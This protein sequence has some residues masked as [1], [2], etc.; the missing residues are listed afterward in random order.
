[1]KKH[2]HVSKRWGILL[3]ICFSLQ[4][5]AQSNAKR[6]KKYEAHY[7]NTEQISN[8][9]K[10]SCIELEKE[11]R[12][13]IE[14]EHVVAKH[15]ITEF[16]KN[17]AYQPAWNEY[18]SFKDVI[19]ALRGIEGNGLQLEDYH[20]A[21]FDSLAAKIEK[22]KKRD[23][24][25][26]HWV[27]EFDILLTDALFTYA[28]H[29]FYGKTNPQ[30]FDANWNYKK[31]EFPSGMVDTLASAIKKKDISKRLLQIEPRFNGYIKMK[32]VLIQYNK[33]ANNG[34]W[35]TVETNKILRPG[36]SDKGIIQV[37]N[38][39]LISNE[40]TDTHF[41]DSLFYD[42]SLKVDIAHFQK[43]HGLNPDG[44]IGKNTLLA[45]NIS[46]EKKIEMIKVNMERDR[47][48]SNAFTDYFVLVNIAA[49]EAYIFKDFKRIHTT[50]AMVGK[51]YHQT[52]VFTAKMQYVE[53][54]PTWTV[55]TSITKK[56][57]IPKMQRDKTYLSRNH[58]EV[59][60]FQG[61][62]VD[63][64]KIDFKNLTP[65]SSFPYMLRQKPGP[66]NALG[67]V[68][69][70]F[71]NSFS[72]YLHDTPSR[73]LFARENRSLSHGCIRIE[74]PL[75]F[76]TAILEN[77]EYDRTAINNI[78]KSQ[79]TQRIILKQKP[80]VMLLYLTVTMGE[81]GDLRFVN[82]IYKRDKRVYNA[83]TEI[84]E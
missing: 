22:L 83:L 36:D 5:Q 31:L 42:D 2:I 33:I 77:T 79:D 68:K 41:T 52:P 21:A 74:N 25:S 24:Y 29:L 12:L 27:A 70:I 60:D 76:A 1:M 15:F 48:V 61:N 4:I 65:T 45:L 51:T 11:K 32:E 47:W 6:A 80:D 56:E 34:G 58:M 54:N 81:N 64:S 71:P 69:F 40:L 38:R 14:G 39:L 44:V 18:E 75:D 3:I 84:K 28:Y 82:D 43:N 7:S 57:L 17:R 35:G 9:I 16:Y 37:R 23:Y 73:S 63:T 19:E 72:V 30:S 13:I 8:E 49:F 53:F 50:K 26:T 10:S 20:V 66:W 62:V 59:L 67:Q 55:P 78:I 46:V